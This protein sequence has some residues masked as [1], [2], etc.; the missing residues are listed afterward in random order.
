MGHHGRLVQSRLSI[1]NQDITVLQVSQ[2]LLVDSRSSRC[3]TVRVG[4]RGSLLRRQQLVCDGR[5]FLDCFSLQR[6]LLS[7]LVLN[8]HRPR[9]RLG[10]VDNQLAHDM[11]VVRCYGLRERELPGK[12]RR[13]TDLI[14]LNID[15]G[16]DDGTS[17]EVDTFSLWYVG[18][19]SSAR[20]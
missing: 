7:V 19:I 11:H 6:D 13:H 18:V 15:I 1:Q 8:H 14:R 2:D 3:Q 20:T 12:D 10:S 4:S 16:R 9:I 5:T 17:R